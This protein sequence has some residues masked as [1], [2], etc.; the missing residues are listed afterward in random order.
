MTVEAKLKALEDRVRDLEDQGQIRE[1][2]A[3]Y[4]FNADLGRSQEW[5]DLW[6]GDGVYDLDSRKWTG[7]EQLH[8]LIASP[9]EPHK[10][11]VENRS[12]HNVLNLFIRIEGD[13]AWAEG[14]SVVVLNKDGQ[15][16]L[17]TCGYNHWDFERHDGQWLLQ[18]RYRRDIGGK[19]WGGKVISSYL[20][21]K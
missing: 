6:T 20:T 18:R 7:R 12:Q 10:R 15:F 8:E 16:G 9:T 4:G 2:L 19:E 14:Y 1:V 17:W 5:V 21:A 3:R 13:R 11:D